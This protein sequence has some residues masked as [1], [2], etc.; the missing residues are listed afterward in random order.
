MATTTNNV[1]TGAADETTGLLLFPNNNGSADD[2]DDGEHHQKK[3][4]SGGCCPFGVTYLVIGILVGILLT[5]TTLFI[6][7]R[8]FVVVIPVVPPASSSQQQQQQQEGRDGE[9]KYRATQ[10]ISFSINTMGGV[11]EYGECDDPNLVDPDDGLCYLGN[12]Q[13]LTEDVEHRY[14]ILKSVFETMKQDDLSSE[15]SKIVRIT[16]LFVQCIDIL[17]AI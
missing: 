5:V 2:D 8:Q 17:S 13:N 12:A 6:V 7:G 16:C 1:A 15:V 9:R 4:R 14:L 10:F 11:A 3:T